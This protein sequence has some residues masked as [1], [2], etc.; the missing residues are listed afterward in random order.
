G[1]DAGRRRG[2]GELVAAGQGPV[3]TSVGRLFDALGSIVT[4]RAVATYEAQAAIELEALARRVERVDAPRWERAVP[5]DRSGALPQL[6]PR[7]LVTRV[8]EAVAQGLAPAVVAAAIH[9]ALGSAAAGLAVELA[10]AHGLDTVALTG[11]VYQNLRL[12][13]VV[14]DAVRAAG[15]TVL[16]H[17]RIPA[18]DAGISIG[19]A[20]VA[21]ATTP[22]AATTASRQR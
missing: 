12:T 15:V 2:V 21:A 13:E 6:D 10:A 11:G 19:Q 8:T 22:A 1:V 14:E 7:P 5:V 3:T 16:V 4:G 18:N 20:A 9:E 17:E